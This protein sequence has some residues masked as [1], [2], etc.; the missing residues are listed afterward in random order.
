MEAWM[1]KLDLSSEQKKAIQEGLKTPE[2]IK[3]FQKENK[4][5]NDGIV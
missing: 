3:A 2:A 5:N 4:L 1:K